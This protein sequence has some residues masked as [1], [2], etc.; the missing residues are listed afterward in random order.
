MPQR[1]GFEDT[2]GRSLRLA[3]TAAI[4][5]TTSSFLESEFGVRVDVVAAKP[6]PE[7]LVESIVSWDR[8]DGFK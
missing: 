4:G 7:S 1:E 5:P 6:S 3:Q 8:D 2:A